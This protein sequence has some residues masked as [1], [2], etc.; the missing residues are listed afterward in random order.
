MTPLLPQAVFLCFVS[1][2]APAP[3]PFPLYLQ[4]GEDSVWE[5]GGLAFPGSSRVFIGFGFGFVF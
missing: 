1:L 5:D 3:P 2:A 4:A